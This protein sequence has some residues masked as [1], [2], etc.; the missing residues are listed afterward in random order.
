MQ[1]F[2]YGTRISDPKACQSAVSGAFVG[3]ISGS[4][5]FL[6]GTVVPSGIKPW[7]RQN[8]PISLEVELQEF[9]GGIRGPERTNG[10]IDTLGITV[11]E[12][13]QRTIDTSEI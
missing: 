2:G 4:G 12:V 8:L 11:S 9:C 6:A 5:I 1:N 7:F 13:R 3:N 10:P